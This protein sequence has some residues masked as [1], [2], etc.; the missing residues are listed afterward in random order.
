MQSRLLHQAGG[1]RTF[2][3]VLKTGE[4]ALCFRPQAEIRIQLNNF[5]SKADVRVC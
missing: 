3:I 2:V 5:G 1:Q 4:E